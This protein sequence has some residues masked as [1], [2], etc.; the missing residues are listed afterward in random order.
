MND[1]KE[2]NKF[3]WILGRGWSWLYRK[4]KKMEVKTRKNRFKSVL[5][6]TL[7]F[8]KILCY[9]IKEMSNKEKE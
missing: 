1:V 9:N 5:V 4:M 6:A 3:G 2:K 8:A 7:D